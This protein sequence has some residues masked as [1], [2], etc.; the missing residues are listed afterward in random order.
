MDLKY[1]VRPPIVLI[2][3]APWKISQGLAGEQHADRLPGRLASNRP[4][5]V[6]G[7]GRTYFHTDQYRQL[8]LR[9]LSL[10]T[11]CADRVSTVAER[12][13]LSGAQLH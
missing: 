5:G 13:L 6:R 12:S 11:L 2:E 9:R 3:A 10:N 1:R 7:S 8:E 4:F